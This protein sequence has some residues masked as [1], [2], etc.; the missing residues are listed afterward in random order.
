MSTP[1]YYSVLGVAAES[2][3]GEIQKAFYRLSLKC[4]PDKRGKSE[5]D[6]AHREYV[7]ISAAYNVLKDIQSRQKYDASR[8]RATTNQKQQ[9]QEKHDAHHDEPHEYPRQRPSEE[10]AWLKFEIAMD[11]F[12]SLRSRIK[13]DSHLVL[14]WCQSL[15]EFEALKARAAKVRKQ[16]RII[17]VAIAK[18]AREFDNATSPVDLTDSSIDLVLHLCEVKQH[19]IGRRLNFLLNR[20][21]ATGS[22]SEEEEERATVASQILVDALERWIKLLHNL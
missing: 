15:E 17:K 7:L 20:L 3:F 22:L 5:A 8:P 6:Q 18:L 2:T 11:S 1:D 21:F 10:E 4:H 12:H 19:I 16:L 14:R 9:K 13:D